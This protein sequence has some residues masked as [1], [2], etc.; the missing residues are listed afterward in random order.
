VTAPPVHV[1]EYSRFDIASRDFWS[2]T[3]DGRD[4]IFAQLRAGE[5]LTWHRPFDSLFPMDEPGFW[6]LTRRAD[7]VHVSQ[8][9]ELFTSA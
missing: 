5:G 6:A 3:F 1:R 4:E 9:P 8:H 2:R 7:I